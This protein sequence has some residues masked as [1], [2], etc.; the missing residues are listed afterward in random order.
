MDNILISVITLAFNSMN[1]IFE[2]IE[3]ILV[4]DYEAIEIII[5]D[6]S[7]SEFDLNKIRLYI[8]EHK[9][10][11]IV[12]TK[13]YQNEKNL[14]TVKSL[15]R[16]VKNASGQIIMHLS[17][18]DI[19]YNTHIISDIVKE[20][21]ETNC[22]ILLTRRA[23]FETDTDNIVKYIPN[24]YQILRISQFKTPLQEYL[25]QYIGKFY[26]MGSGSALYY[27]KE[28]IEELGYFDENYRLWEDGPLFAKITRNG[29]MLHYN[30]NIISIYYKL[31]G[32]S[33]GVIPLDLQNDV[34][35]FINEGIKSGHAKGINKRIMKRLYFY[36]TSK[37]SLLEKRI[38]SCFVYPDV[39]LYQLFDKV[40]TKI[41]YRK[42][43][44]S[45]N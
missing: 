2:T 20:F 13:I 35:K 23:A 24:D 37:K 26:D 33:T 1:T 39:C 14:G 40:I 19:F 32:V 22:N 44:K 9:S 38:I 5:A 31:G 10:K 36:L 29:G 4:Q 25:G 45:E 6:D 16:A 11:N 28:Y 34:I 41:K 15:N 3:S 30:Y 43:L 21:E 18:D 12:S 42:Y 8:E 7:S 17:A 27:R